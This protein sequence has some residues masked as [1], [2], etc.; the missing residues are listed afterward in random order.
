M[1][2]RGPQ[3]Q[4]SGQHKMQACFQTLVSACQCSNLCQSRQ[5]AVRLFL[6]TIHWWQ[7]S[8]ADRPGDLM[9]TF[10]STCQFFECKQW[11]WLHSS[12]KAAFG[13]S[14]KTAA[15]TAVVMKDSMALLTRFGMLTL[16]WWPSFNI[17]CLPKL[18]HSFSWILCSSLCLPNCY[19]VLLCT[20]NHLPFSASAGTAFQWWWSDLRQSI[21]KTHWDPCIKGLIINA[22]H[23]R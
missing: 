5:Q 4:C 13:M 2:S 19:V 10:V 8:T 16:L 22:S 20:V 11:A 14:G 3:L 9:K 18:P 15:L 23:Y 6:I 1:W 12:W 7:T 17:F 21:C